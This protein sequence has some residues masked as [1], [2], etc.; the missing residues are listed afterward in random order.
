MDI[1]ILEQFEQKID[2]LL[3]NY[4]DIKQENHRLRNDHTKL[5]LE[6]SKLR[7]KQTLLRERIEA[8]IERLRE[9]EGTNEII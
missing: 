5:L 4:M 2:A 7:K 1:E 9:T 6:N 8:I 3:K